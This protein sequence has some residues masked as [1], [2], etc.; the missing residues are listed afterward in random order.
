MK[1]KKKYIYI[2]RSPQS[3]PPQFWDN[4]LCIQVFHQCRVHQVDCG[5]LIHCSWGCCDSFAFLL[6]VCPLLGF[7]FGF[8]PTPV[9]RS[10][11]SVFYSLR[12]DGVKEAAD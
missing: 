6:F 12:L 7:S 4:L 3:S 10:P 9:Y 5:D 2:Y 11:V 8:G 1:K